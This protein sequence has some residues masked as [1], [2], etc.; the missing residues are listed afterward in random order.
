MPFAN[1]MS[2]H[3]RS[4]TCQ[5]RAAVHA[6]QVFL[7]TWKRGSKMIQFSARSVVLGLAFSN[8]QVN[9]GVSCAHFRFLASEQ[10]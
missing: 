10:L 4:T 3:D 5:N 8:N 9:T 2:P 1:V 7:D 6:L